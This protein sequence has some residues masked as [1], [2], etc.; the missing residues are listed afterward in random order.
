MDF[1]A[2]S[3]FA[4]DFETGERRLIFESPEY[5]PNHIAVSPDERFVAADTWADEGTDSH[6]NPMS[7]LLLADTQTGEQRILCRFPRHQKHPGHPHPNFSPDGTKIAF[8]IADGHNCQMAVE[9]LGV[10]C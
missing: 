1:W 10:G 6:G 4:V 8:T 3:V 2:R 7:G 9:H 5:L